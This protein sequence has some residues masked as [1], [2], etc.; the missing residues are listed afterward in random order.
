MNLP[1]TIKSVE[2]LRRYYLCLLEATPTFDSEE[3]KWYSESVATLEAAI[4][5]LRKMN[6]QCANN[7]DAERMS[8]VLSAS[9][10]MGLDIDGRH[11]WTTM[12]P[13]TVRGPN[14]RAAIDAAIGK[15]EGE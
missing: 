7:L 9:R 1:D 11:Y 6:E 4:T 15:G 13:S 14:L 12:Y 5:H 3:S 8:F 2:E 10:P